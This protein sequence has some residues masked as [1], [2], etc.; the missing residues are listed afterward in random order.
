MSHEEKKMKPIWYLVGWM[1]LIN[2]VLI[3]ASGIYYFFNPSHY[4]T[5]LAEL[6]PSIWWGAMML[7]VGGIM[8]IASRKA[9]EN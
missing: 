6:H 2:G 8:L 4:R 3:F 1:L 5:V 9:T 7:V